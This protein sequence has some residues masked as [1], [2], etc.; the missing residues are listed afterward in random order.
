[1]FTQE[2]WGRLFD[3]T[4]EE[5]R[6]LAL[7]KGG[8]YSGDAERLRNFRWASEEQGIPQELVWRIYAGKHWDAIGQ[9]VKDLL[10]G[11]ERTRGEPIEG[12]AH[13]LIVYLLLFLAMCEE[14]AESQ[15]AAP[16]NQM[17]TERFP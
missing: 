4:I 5:C 17:R 2:Q 15:K 7:V 16:D 8:E 3:R 14:R 9:Y 10:D 11:R 6:R 13:D 12:R 1:M